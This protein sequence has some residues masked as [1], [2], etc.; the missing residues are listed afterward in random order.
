MTIWVKTDG[1]GNALVY[2]YNLNRLR[3]DNPNTSFPRELS[4]ELAAG[5]DVYPVTEVVPEHD[6]A[7]Y[8]AVRDGVVPVLTNGVW[9]ATFVLVALSV[10]DKRGKSIRTMSDELQT[11]LNSSGLS[12]RELLVLSSAYGEVCHYLIDNSFPTPIIDAI[13][14]EFPGLTKT[15]VGTKVKN[16]YETYIVE[17]AAALARNIKRQEQIN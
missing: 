11:S 7:E 15:Q 9:T 1:E 5:F 16:R 13:H 8:K 17:A 12:D 14:G 10:G 3:K 6:P 2:P 4:E